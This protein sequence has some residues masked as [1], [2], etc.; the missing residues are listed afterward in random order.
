MA[1][2]GYMRVSCEDQ[3]AQ[4]QKD[5]L[6]TAGCECVYAD[7]GVS[8]ISKTRPGFEAA[9]ECLQPNDTLVVWKLDRAF[10]SVK[11]AIDTLEH[12]ERQRIAFRS[13]T[14]YVDTTSPMGYAMYQMQNV[15]S[16]LE[17][18][19]IS[20][21]TKAGLAAAR[22]RGKR[23]GRPPKLS[24]SQVAWA[25]RVLRDE[26]ARTTKEL[27]LHFGVS[28]RTLRRALKLVAR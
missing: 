5:A 12:L 3:N 1:V 11:Q 2:I 16:E 24:Q 28:H 15:F 17:R 25:R 22:R 26:P 4:L 19:L 8:A 7:L 21:R 27:A 13:L 6:R 10:R 20:E 9:L 14:E 18:K 23:L